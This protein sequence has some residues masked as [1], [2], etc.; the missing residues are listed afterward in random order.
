MRFPL[1][2]DQ[3][4]AETSVPDGAAR[5]LV[6]YDVHDGSIGKYGTSGGRLSRRSEVKLAIAGLRTHSLWSCEYGTLYVS[7]GDLMLISADLAS[8]VLRAGVG[9]AEMFYVEVNGV[10]YYSNGTITGTVT[11]S[12]DGTWGSPVPAAPVATAITTGGLS[13]GIYMVALTYKDANGRESGASPTTL[14]QVAEGGGISISGIINNGYIVRVYASPANGEALYW[15]QDTTATVAY[16]GTHQPGKLLATQYMLPPEPCTLLDEYNGRIYGVAGNALVA[17]QAMNY[18]LTRPSVDYVL[19]AD[20]PIMNKSVV[21]G[22]YIGNR[23]GVTF[24]SGGD[25][26]QFTQRSVDALPPIPGSAMKV[27]GSLFESARDGVVWLTRR[28]WVF[29][30]P[31]GQIKRLTDS[32][33]ALPDYD[34]AAGLYREHDGMR[35]LMTFVKGGGEAAGASDSYDVEIVRNGRVVSS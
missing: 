33:M 21:D 2:V 8:S 3:V 30:G 24:L 32:K 9:E 14:I 5:R 26:G 23:H 35:Q 34:R 17:T 27:D 22:I 15:V 19:F 10:I 20:A 4:S 12:V 13:A 6:N 28:G 18:G 16:I 29:G 31:S 11:N 25:I 7:A 1:G